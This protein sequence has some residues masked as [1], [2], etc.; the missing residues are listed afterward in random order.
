MKT[1]WGVVIA[2]V[3]IAAAI[4]FGSGDIAMVF[5]TGVLALLTAGLLVLT[6]LN[7]RIAHRI[8]WFTGAMERHSDQMRQL[9]ARAQGVEMIWWDKT[10]SDNQFPFH[11]KH[12]KS[13][14]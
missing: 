11:G 13:T 3:L 14:I 12:A 4:Y 6:F 1:G 8:E 9:E 10:K 5:V 7:L 2:G